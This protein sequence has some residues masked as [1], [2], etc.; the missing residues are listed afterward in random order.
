M[1]D[2]H[3][4]LITMQAAFHHVSNKRNVLKLIQ[5]KLKPSGT[6][7][8][9]EF[10]IQNGENALLADLF[11]AKNFV[12]T[13]KISP[14]DFIREYFL[15]YVTRQQLEEMLKEVG[16]EIKNVMKVTP[17]EMHYIEIGFIVK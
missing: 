11:H 9:Y 2:C 15:E 12:F 6:F 8:M 3:F 16:L 17:L 7:I 14:E 5:K 13:G 4:D 10:L 1:Q